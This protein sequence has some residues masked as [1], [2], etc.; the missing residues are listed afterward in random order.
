MCIM[1]T[2]SIS[3]SHCLRFYVSIDL[4]FIVYLS[5]SSSI[6]H[7]L[8]SVLSVFHRP[9]T[10]WPD[11]NTYLFKLCASPPPP[12]PRIVWAPYI[13]HF[14]PLVCPTRGF[15]G[16]ISERGDCCCLS[17]TSGAMRGQLRT[18]WWNG[19]AG[20]SANVPALHFL[21]DPNSSV[22]HPLL[23]QHSSHKTFHPNYFC[24]GDDSLRFSGAC[25]WDTHQ[26]AVSSDGD[27]KHVN[28][29][30]MLEHWSTHWILSKKNDLEAKCQSD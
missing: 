14:R 12:T 9:N 23:D 11:T 29:K 5:L 26:L 7:K 22:F 6:T 30:Q 21:D 24:M 28:I 27:G 25:S 2:F 20:F 1:N 19:S 16:L 3:Q 4:F 8:H 17:W 18:R 13:S 10:D 15:L